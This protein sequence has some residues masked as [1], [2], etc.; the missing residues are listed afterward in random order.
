MAKTKRESKFTIIRDEDI[1]IKCHLCVRMCAFD[2]HSYEEKEDTKV[3]TN[4]EHCVGCCFCIEMC[5]TGALHIV[6]NY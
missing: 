3:I 5:P 4:S 1:C 2:T 6:K